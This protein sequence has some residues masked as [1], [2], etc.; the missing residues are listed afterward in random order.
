[1]R[2]L[3][4]DKGC[5]YLYICMCTCAYVYAC[6]EGCVRVFVPSERQKGFGGGTPSNGFIRLLGFGVDGVND[7]ITCAMRL[8][9]CVHQ[10]IC[11]WMWSQS[12][13]HARF[14]F[15]CSKRFWQSGMLRTFPSHGWA[16]TRR[17]ARV[18]RI[19]RPWP[20]RFTRRTFPPQRRF[21]LR[22]GTTD[23]VWHAAHVQCFIIGL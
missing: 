11:V 9:I 5:I 21:A 4:V 7:L 1:M 20:K 23:T 14:R 22:T 3:S 15:Y 12:R 18:W 8:C 17:Q 13:N 16:T 10:N 6:V 19:G 2:N